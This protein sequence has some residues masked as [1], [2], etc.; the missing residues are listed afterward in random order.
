M[1]TCP[2]QR[3]WSLHTWIPPPDEALSIVCER[4]RRQQ[5][6][7]PKPFSPSPLMIIVVHPSQT[8]SPRRKEEV[9]GIGV[10]MDDMH[11]PPWVPVRSLSR[12]S[13][14]VRSNRGRTG[15]QAS[16]L[17]PF[18]HL[19]TS[20]AK[21]IRSTLYAVV[22]SLKENVGMVAVAAKLPT[23]QW[24]PYAGRL[25]WESHNNRLQIQSGSS[26]QMVCLV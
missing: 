26:S 21:Q 6:S 24:Y 9:I 15:S 14:P 2:H 18:K 20:A 8:R 16:V 5:R 4:Q 25:P 11:A 22:G 17:F 1:T 23:Y 12:R 19:R 3:L 7:T 13:V 10:S